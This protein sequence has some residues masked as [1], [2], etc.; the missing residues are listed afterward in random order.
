MAHFC[1]LTESRI[2]ASPYTSDETGSHG[3]YARDDPLPN[4]GAVI[5]PSL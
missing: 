1:A 5:F 4:R 2:A 3:A